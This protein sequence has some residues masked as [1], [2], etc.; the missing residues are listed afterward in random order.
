MD[1]R[2]RRPRLGSLLLAVLLI[3]G[4]SS[5][6]EDV[7]VTLCKDLVRGLLNEPQGLTWTE[8]RNEMS[9]S[10]RLSV[11]LRFTDQESTGGL[12][13]PMRATCDYRYNA[14]DETALTLSDPMAAYATS[15]YRMTLND[16][17]IGNPLL[18]RAIKGAM[19]KQ[20]REFLERAQRGI[21]EGAAQ[22]QRRFDPAQPVN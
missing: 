16:R 7:R 11:Q 14:V 17:V 4:C 18:A 8:T 19:L 12:A 15:P 9:R 2:P 20:G 13:K 22:L 1:F 5:P 10:E 6:G 3:T 21:N